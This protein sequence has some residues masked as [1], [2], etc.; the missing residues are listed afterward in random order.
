ME[1]NLDG[2]KLPDS[3]TGKNLTKD[4]MKC[5]TATKVIAH[6][7]QCAFLFK[8]S[9]AENSKLL[10]I[11]LI[12]GLIFNSG[13]VLNLSVYVKAPG[14]SVSGK[15]KLRVMYANGETGKSTAK[16]ET[17]VDYAEVIGTLELARSDVVRVKFEIDH[18][19]SGG[20]VY[21]DDA[22]LIWIP[23]GAALDRGLIPLP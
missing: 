18:R 23:T 19:S 9:P 3:W 5:D 8:G 2:D 22:S 10:Q 1:A 7:G 16:L 6:T 13:D 4:K 15:I 17:S 21:L 14:A 20:K 12:D 11:A